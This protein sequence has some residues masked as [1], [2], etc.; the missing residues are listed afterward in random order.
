MA[1]G[2]R[3][4]YHHASEVPLEI[5]AGDVALGTT[6]D[7]YAWAQAARLGAA[8][9]GFA[10]P[11]GESMVNPD[12]IAV[13]RGAPHPELARRFVEFTLTEPGQL[14]WM[15][16]PGAAGG[17]E[18]Y[19]LGRMPI[20][21]PVWRAHR[22]RAT[23][24]LDPFAARRNLRYDSRLGSQRWSLVNGLIGTLLVD[25]HRELVTG[26]QSVVAAGSPPVALELLTRPPLAEAEVERLAGGDYRDPS[27]RNRLLA[28][29]AREAL[30]RYRR[31]ARLGRAQG[32]RS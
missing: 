15:L 21:E 10:A 29:W 31:A 32:G 8:A 4:I 2:S 18:R 24:A 14:L 12:A 20:V 9:I 11:E 23:V 3:R 7:S 30:D 1:A 17:P 26:Y 6:I 25:L 5:G 27:R 22:A 13:L 19:V 28:G 16:P